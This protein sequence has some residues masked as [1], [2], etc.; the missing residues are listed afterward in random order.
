MTS[1]VTPS[2]VF[3][4][5]LCHFNQFSQLFR[6]FGSLK[7]TSLVERCQVSVDIRNQV[8]PNWFGWKYDEWERQL[9]LLQ[10]LRAILEL[11]GLLWLSFPGYKE[12]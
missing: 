5:S 12:H 2:S 3:L 1:S 9:T 6:G 4:A 10:C 11:T 8:F 7:V